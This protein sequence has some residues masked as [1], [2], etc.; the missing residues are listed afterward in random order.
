MEIK[1]EMW[2]E[3]W[4]SGWRWTGTPAVGG[5]VGKQVQRGGATEPCVYGNQR[6]S[7]LSRLTFCWVEYILLGIQLWPPFIG[8]SSL[9]SARSPW[10]HPRPDAGTLFL[11]VLCYG[12]DAFFPR[13]SFSFYHVIKITHKNLNIQFRAL[14]IYFQVLQYGLHSFIQ[15]KN[16]HAVLQTQLKPYIY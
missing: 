16:P 7:G 8:A 1:K 12:C 5:R 14:C 3:I 6:R 11:A 9:D 2:K 13:K 4:K 15:I 10:N